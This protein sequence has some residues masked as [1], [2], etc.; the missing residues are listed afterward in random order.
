[1]PKIP[2]R[3][4]W[5]VFLFVVI[6][7]LLLVIYHPAEPRAV[8]KKWR[9]F[10]KIETLEHQEVYNKAYRRK[11][12]PYRL[13]TSMEHTDHIAIDSYGD[14]ITKC[15]LTVVL[16]DPRLPTSSPG[17]PVWFAL[18]SVALHTDDDTCFLL[19]T[20]LGNKMLDAD[21]VFQHIYY[22]SFP[23]F[24]RAIEQNRVRVTFLDTA[25]YNM[26]AQ[27][28]SFNPNAAFLNVHYWKD[29][30]IDADSDVVLIVQ[31]DTVL[32]RELDLK[33]YQQY[34]WVGAVWPP[35]A[36]I[37]FPLPMEGM[38]RGMP[39]RWKSWLR[40][41]RKWEKQQ[42]D[43]AAGKHVESPLS[44]PQPLMNSNFPAVCNNGM[45]P[46]G[47]GGL[48]LRNRTWMIH[49]IQAC[50][51]DKLSGI[52]D[53]EKLGC[54]VLDKDNE[55]FYF[56]TILR[57]MSAPLP[58]GHEAALFSSESL[59]PQ[60]VIKLYYNGADDKNDDGGAPTI[61]FEGRVLS[62]PMGFHKP[63]AYQSNDLL[64]S[65]QLEDSCPLLRYIFE[66]EQ[67]RYQSSS[68]EK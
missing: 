45:A 18:E 34:A 33:R 65:D 12:L 36:S 66:P 61:S 41:Q 31:S 40:P 8:G 6:C 19:Q 25:K 32:C 54:K 42:A 11:D 44:K 29:E 9:K 53:F 21:A 1:M 52:D 47:N 5:M 63:W 55:D 30:F 67:S 38:C 50:P 14:Q 46:V 3:L 24:Q 35:K 20:S 43:I 58:D 68:E 57:G 23:S 28:D 48:S 13:G 17:Q 62:V 26:K 4:F 60:D 39:A 10:R 59:W 64:L 2:V 22:Q 27:D 37:N 16:M 15:T 51:H 7:S 49:A 56:G